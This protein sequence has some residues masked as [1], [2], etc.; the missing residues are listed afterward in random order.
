ML[1]TEADALKANSKLASHWSNGRVADIAV[2]K[3]PPNGGKSAHLKAEPAQ[4]NPISESH[5]NNPVSAIEREINECNQ[6]LQDWLGGNSEQSD[7]IFNQL[8]AQLASGFNCIMSDGRMMKRDALLTRLHD[9]YGVK[10]HDYR[11]TID[12]LRVIVQTAILAVVSYDEHEFFTHRLESTESEQVSQ[13]HDDASE[14]PAARPARSHYVTAVLA[15]N[16]GKRNS[17]EWLHRH[18]TGHA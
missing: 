12:N 2:L 7:E 16:N 8:S 13:Y 14:P 3:V 9:H 17:I 15:L 11:L 10:G 5:I 18:E 4:K 1:R 6:I